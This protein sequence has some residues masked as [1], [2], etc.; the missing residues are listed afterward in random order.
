MIVLH[1]FKT[2]PV[3]RCESSKVLKWTPPPTGE[4]MVNVDAALFPVQ[5][6]MAVGAVFRD[7]T[8]L[9]VLAVSEPLRGFTSPELAEA[10]ALLRAVTVAKEQRYTKVI[11]A[12]DCLSLIQRIHSCKPDRSMVGAVVSDI[13][14]LVA[15][16][17]SATFRHVYRSLNEAGHIL[18]RS[19]DVTSPGFISFS[20]PVSIRKTLCI[21]V[22]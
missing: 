9:C 8:G 1:C 5:R 3:S 17:D 18:A 4:V 20:A 21:D 6:R 22:M 15:G 7:H 13:K 11:F 12:S 2:K 10:L 19:C 16:F 14:L